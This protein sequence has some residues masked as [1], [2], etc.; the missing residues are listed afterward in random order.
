[1]PP[2]VLEDSPTVQARRTCPGSLHP[3]PAQNHKSSLPAP[4]PE[5][6]PAL[7]NK[8]NTPPASSPSSVSLHIDRKEPRHLPTLRSSMHLRQAPHLPNLHPSCTALQR[9]A[10]C[11]Q[12]WVVSHLSQ[13]RNYIRSHCPS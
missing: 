2:P 12:L 1:M 7:R 4:D 9:T 5:T 6:L 11:N 8:S 13:S 10:T 3:A